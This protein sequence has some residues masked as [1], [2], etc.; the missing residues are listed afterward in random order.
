MK[1]NLTFNSDKQEI[2]GVI[3]IKKETVRGTSGSSADIDEAGD[4]GDQ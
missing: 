1:K 2:T 4:D 3:S